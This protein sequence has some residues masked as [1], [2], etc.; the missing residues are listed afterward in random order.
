MEI[1][2]SEEGKYKNTISTYTK[3]IID[4]FPERIVGTTVTPA[5][6]HL[7]K[8]REEA[9]ATKLPDEQASAFHRTTA[10][11]LFLSGSVRRDI[12]TAVAF[13]IT[14]VDEDDRGKL[15]RVL[16]YLNGMQGLGLTLSMKNMGIT[17]WYMGTSYTTHM[18]CY[19]HMGAMMTMGDSAAICISPKQE[20]IA[21]SLTEV[22]LIGIYDALSSVLHA[23]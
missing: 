3:N 10:E 14:W 11:L 22:E 12:Q 23:K 18:Y 21:W 1:D 17:R 20:T 19:G 13:L 16:K 4:S 6:D 5:V 15:K 9:E 8:V 7:I 2:Y